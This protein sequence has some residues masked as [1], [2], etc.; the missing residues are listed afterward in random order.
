[1]IKKEIT[2]VDFL[3]TKRTEDAYFH[4]S[5]QEMKDMQMSVEGGMDKLL[6]KMINGKDDKEIYNTFVDIVLKSYGV[7]SPDGRFH[8]KEDEDGHKLYKRFIQSPA[9]DALMD[10]ICKDTESITNFIN[11]IMPQ[12]TK[13]V[14]KPNGEYHPNK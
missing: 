2:Y 5:K 6:E 8:M 10:D 13:I 3:G 7:L 9:Y 14:E 4:L 12:D 1:M 11:G